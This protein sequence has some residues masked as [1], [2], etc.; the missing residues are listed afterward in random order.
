MDLERKL[1]ASVENF[2][3]EGKMAIGGWP[4][5]PQDFPRI[6]FHQPA[7]IFAGKRPVDD[8]AFVAGT[9]RNFPGFADS[10][11]GGQGFGKEA[12]QF[13]SAPDSLLKNGLEDEWIKHEVG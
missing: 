4:G 10:F 8:D 9:I 12:F 6:S 7:Q 2:A 3:Q 13:A 1:V 11:A 5:L